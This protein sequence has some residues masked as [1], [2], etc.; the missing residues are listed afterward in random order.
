LAFA[1]RN[2][3][4]G[5]ISNSVQTGYKQ[6]EGLNMHLPHGILSSIALSLTLGF[7]FGFAP[8]L[9]KS[10]TPQ[11]ETPSPENARTSN[12]SVY[13]LDIK[14]QDQNGQTQ[15]WSANKGRVR[16]VTMFYS[17]CPHTCPLTIESIKILESHLH[18]LSR[19]RLEVD[20]ISLDPNRDT[21]PKLKATA[22]SRNIDELRWHLYRTDANSVRQIAGLL[23]VQYRQLP[24]GEFNHSSILV[25][26]D[27]KGRILAKSEQT[28]KEDQKFIIAVARALA[29]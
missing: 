20:L 13:Q 15:P 9:A 22:K 27:S 10:A 24:D 11:S 8:E 21:A 25:L 1:A 7:A 17:S 14:L 23:G 19:E 4:K 18:A 3:V 16:I 12:E 2:R 29:R 28:G 5:P 6:F 26:L